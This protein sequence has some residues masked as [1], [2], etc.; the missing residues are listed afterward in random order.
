[1]LELLRYMVSDI[2]KLI[3]MVNSL[4]TSS[5]KMNAVLA[6]HTHPILPGGNPVTA[7]LPGAAPSIELGIAAATDSVGK[8]IVD[9]TSQV[10]STINSITGEMDYLKAGGSKFIISKY[11][12]T[13]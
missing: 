8:T 4:T 10:S 13:N 11:N 5:L 1:L 7:P 3:G 2:R 9:F 12:N 6:A